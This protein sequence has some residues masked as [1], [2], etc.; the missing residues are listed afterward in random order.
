[1]INWWL[2][3]LSLVGFLVIAIILFLYALKSSVN[4]EDSY[5]VDPLPNDE[6]VKKKE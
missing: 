4:M 2:T 1:M 3:T 5:R 6:D